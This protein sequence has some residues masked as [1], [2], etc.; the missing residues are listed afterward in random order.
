MGDKWVGHSWQKIR[1]KFFLLSVFVSFLWHFIIRRYKNQLH[2]E[3][4]KE[5]CSVRTKV[6]SVMAQT[7]VD[8]LVVHLKGAMK[9]TN[10]EHGVKL[11]GAVLVDRPLNK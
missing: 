3:E 6:H 5:Y 8:D 7:D 1:A 11:V 10:M 2:L 9:L 4:V